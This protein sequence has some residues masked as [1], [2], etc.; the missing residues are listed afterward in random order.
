[1][2]VITLNV[3][4]VRSASKKGVFEWLHEEKADVICLQ[5]TRW[6]LAHLQPHFELPGY[7][8]YFSHAEKKGYS[9]VA[10]Y[11]RTPPDSVVTQ[12]GWSMADQEGRYL[13]LDFGNLSI[14]SIYIPSG[15]SSDERQQCK[16]DFLERYQSV[17]AQQRQNGRQYILCGDWNIAHRPIDLKNWKANQ[18]HS[19]FLPEERAWFD[20]LLGP[21]GYI[22]A[23][24]IL[25]PGPHHY[26]WW[27]NFGR[28]WDNN[29]GW[30]IDYQIITPAL[31]NTLKSTR[32]Y[33]EKRFSDHAPLILE[34]DIMLNSY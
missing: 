23:F 24:R 13:Q 5:E 19:G 30:R 26:T 34:Y 18:K 29:S 25:E 32:I 2:K 17:L 15:T 28:A 9:G 12:L 27:S 31:K 8:S 4:G 3:N 33:K 22:D 6:Q 20:H 14:V 16:F 10:I 7:Q 1:M 11:S 21:L